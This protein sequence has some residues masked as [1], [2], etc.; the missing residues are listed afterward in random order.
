MKR[1]FPAL[2]IAVLLIL[3]SASAAFADD[4]T[5]VDISPADGSKGYQPAN[6]PVKIRF[7]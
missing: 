6:M 7:S 5:I 3:A 1:R 4:L 2:L